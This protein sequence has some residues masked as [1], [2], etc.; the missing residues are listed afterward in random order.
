MKWSAFLTG[1]RDVVT[2]A[3]GV[4]LLVSQARIAADHP[5]SVNFWLI[6]AGLVLL[7][8]PG[9]IGVFALRRGNGEPEDT[10]EPPSRPRPRASSRR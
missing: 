1:L 8:V 10:P 7:N 5:E 9:V 2:M 3:L 4:Y 6:A